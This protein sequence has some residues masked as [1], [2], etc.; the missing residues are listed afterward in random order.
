MVFLETL[1]HGHRRASEAGRQDG[2]VNAWFG[3]KETEVCAEGTSLGHLRTLAGKMPSEA[4]E[5]PCRLCPRP[6]SQVHLALDT[7]Q[8]SRGRRV[9]WPL[10]QSS[11]PLSYQ[12]VA[13]PPCPGPC[14]P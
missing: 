7:G 13:T 6:Y 9:L 4:Q 12:L 5:L 11:S 8:E 14:Y 2:V 1:P 3:N 10:D